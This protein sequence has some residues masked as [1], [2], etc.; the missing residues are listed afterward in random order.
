MSLQKIKY[1]WVVFEIKKNIMWIQKIRNKKIRKILDNH[2]KSNVTSSLTY[3]NNITIFKN[4]GLITIVC[5]IDLNY[6]NSMAFEFLNESV[7][8]FVKQYKEDK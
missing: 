4:D 6:P 2:I 7:N 1:V 8:S 5:L 3:D